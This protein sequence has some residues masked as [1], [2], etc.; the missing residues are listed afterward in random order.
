MVRKIGDLGFTNFKTILMG[1][2]SKYGKEIY[3]IPRFYPS[4]KTCSDC[5]NVKKELSLKERTFK[6]E[7]CSLEIDRDHN[8]S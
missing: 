6:C 7:H 2:A 5:L 1:Q 3:F 4:S 8:V